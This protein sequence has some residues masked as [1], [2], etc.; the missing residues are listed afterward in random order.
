VFFQQG[1]MGWLKTMY[2][3]KFGIVVDKS[4]TVEKGDA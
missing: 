3:E 1:I 2:P 4:R